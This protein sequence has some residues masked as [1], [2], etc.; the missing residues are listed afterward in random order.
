M[1]L[2]GRSPNPLEVTIQQP[3][4]GNRCTK[5]S[6]RMAVL[7]HKLVTS[8]TTR[9]QSTLVCAHQSKILSHNLSI[10]PDAST[11]LSRLNLCMQLVNNTILPVS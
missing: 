6:T 4:N 3:R 5:C 9:E 2:V 11:N 10:C 1:F 7:I 8:T